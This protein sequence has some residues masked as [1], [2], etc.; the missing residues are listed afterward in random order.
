MR[1][2]F[3]GLLS[4]ENADI[5]T[6]LLSLT[7]LICCGSLLFTFEDSL[8]GVSTF[9]AVLFKSLFGVISVTSVLNLLK[10]SF[11][12][13]VTSGVTVSLAAVIRLIWLAGEGLAVGSAIW[14]LIAVSVPI[15]SAVAYIIDNDVRYKK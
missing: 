13:S 12:W 6:R 4:T 9:E 2:F 10:P 1:K 8:T 3:E 15:A 5:M 7:L 11:M 14:L